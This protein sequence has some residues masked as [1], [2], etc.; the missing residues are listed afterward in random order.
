M[1]RNGTGKPS[2]LELYERMV[3]ELTKLQQTV[4]RRMAES[5]PRAKGTPDRVQSLDGVIPRWGRRG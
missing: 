4:A 2:S 5:N 1:S 3:V